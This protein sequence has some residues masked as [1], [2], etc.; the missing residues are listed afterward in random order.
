[1]QLKNGSIKH[2]KKETKQLLEETFEELG[3]SVNVSEVKESNLVG[4]S[5]ALEII[6]HNNDIDMINSTIRQIDSA[7]IQLNIDGAMIGEFIL[8]VTDVN[9]SNEII[10]LMAADLMYREF[11]WWQSPEHLGR[12]S[13]RH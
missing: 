11:L 12:S 9:D 3:I 8:S 13:W 10:Y 6:N 5:V 2:S 1:M 7:M 4:Y